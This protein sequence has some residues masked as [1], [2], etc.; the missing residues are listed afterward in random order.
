LN[1]TLIKTIEKT[2]VGEPSLTWDLTTDNNNLPIASGMY[3][4]HVEVPGVGSK[5][6][7]FG[8]VKKRT[9]LNTF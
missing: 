1:G 7:K 8:F 2:R 4:V 9:Q 6:I 5:F 3:L